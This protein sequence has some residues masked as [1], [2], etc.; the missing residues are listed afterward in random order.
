VLGRPPR[1][2]NWITPS[3]HIENDPAYLKDL[4]WPL[5]NLDEFIFVR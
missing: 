3:F 2:P 1:D 5:F 4:G